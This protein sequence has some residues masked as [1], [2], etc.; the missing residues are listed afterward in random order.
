MAIEIDLRASLARKETE[1]LMAIWKRRESG[2]WTPQAISTVEALLR[3]RGLDPLSTLAEPGVSALIK[4]AKPVEAL[5]APPETAPGGTSLRSGGQPPSQSDLVLIHWWAQMKILVGVAF[6]A[7]LIGSAGHYQTI[8]G[9][10]VLL[11]GVFLVLVSISALAAVPLA[12]SRA[13][14]SRQNFETARCPRCSVEFYFDLAASR[15]SADEGGRARVSCPT[16]GID[17]LFDSGSLEVKEIR[18]APNRGAGEIG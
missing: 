6:G 7:A 12:L 8:E 17:I 5:S 1:D 3:Q 10:L 11:L 15:K 4:E 13:R 2:D 18:P 16:C 9:G 14:R